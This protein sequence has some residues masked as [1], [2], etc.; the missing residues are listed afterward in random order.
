MPGTLFEVIDHVRQDRMV[1]IALLEV[2]APGEAAR[3][4]EAA[5]LVAAA[6]ESF[7]AVL[8]ERVRRA[9]RSPESSRGRPTRAGPVGP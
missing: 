2:D 5:T 4:A 8:R 3:A 7:R 9:H 6:R 1:Q